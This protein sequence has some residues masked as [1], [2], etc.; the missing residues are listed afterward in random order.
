MECATKMIG[1]LKSGSA[2]YIHTEEVV[3]YLS[4]PQLS[5]SSISTVEQVEQQ[6]PG[7]VRDPKSRALDI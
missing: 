5:S 6:V 4:K 1:T 2:S 7:E 3:A